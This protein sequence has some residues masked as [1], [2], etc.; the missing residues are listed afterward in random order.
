MAFLQCGC[1]ACNRKL[2][3]PRVNVCKAAADNR[4]SVENIKM[5]SLSDQDKEG[6]GDENDD[7]EINAHTVF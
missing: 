1:M 7:S 6:L 5:S 3:Q 2:Q 4:G